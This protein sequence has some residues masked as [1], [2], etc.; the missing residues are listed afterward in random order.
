M[1]ILARMKVCSIFFVR[2]TDGLEKWGQTFCRISGAHICDDR[3]PHKSHCAVLRVHIFRR[4]ILF[5]HLELNYARSNVVLTT[6]S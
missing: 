3:D 4:V 2:A 6:T 1:M 5:V